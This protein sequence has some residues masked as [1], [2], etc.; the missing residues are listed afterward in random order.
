MG[1][2]DHDRLADEPP[3]P[4]GGVRP[5]FRPWPLGL[6]TVCVFIALNWF[7]MSGLRFDGTNHLSARTT[8]G[9]FVLGFPFILALGLLCAAGVTFLWRRVHKIAGWG[10]LALLVALL[11][12]S[13]GAS[14]PER[15]LVA[16]IG[17]RAAQ[18]AALERLEVVDS[19]NAGETA[20]GIISGPDD[21][22]ETIARDRSLELTHP[23]PPHARLRHFFPELFLDLETEPDTGDMA[24]SVGEQARNDRSAFFRP[25]G[26]SRIYFWRE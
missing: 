16:I 6:A 15:R 25:S 2:Q 22:L 8:A 7:S 1:D 14:T 11:A 4:R 12:G 3:R 13:L 21:L 17:P 18:Q 5:Y 26:S 24:A 23:S 19:F 9:W 10:A 20:W